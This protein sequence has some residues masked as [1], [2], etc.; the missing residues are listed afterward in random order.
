[1]SNWA[2]ARVLERFAPAF[3][4]VTREGTSLQYS[5]RINRFLELAPGMPS[6][7][8]LTMARRGLRAPIAGGA[9]TGRRNRRPG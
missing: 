3:V 2:N 8:V 9:E 4:V 7:N 6:Q 5:S 1:M